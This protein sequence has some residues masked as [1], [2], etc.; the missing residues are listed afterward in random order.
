M[1]LPTPLSPCTPPL[2]STP[3][4][5]TKYAGLS[6]ILSKELPPSLLLTLTLTSHNTIQGFT[7]P[8]GC[9]VSVELITAYQSFSDSYKQPVECTHTTEESEDNTDNVGKHE[10][11][12]TF[13]IAVR[14]LTVDSRVIVRYG[15]GGDIQ[16]TKVRLQRN[17]R[18]KG[19]SEATVIV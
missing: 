19:W 12:V 17:A 4:T 5:D 3:L 8:D 10:A 15:W 11:R 14:D 2:P 18:A 16:G 6:Y 1:F 9:I 7:D 13:P